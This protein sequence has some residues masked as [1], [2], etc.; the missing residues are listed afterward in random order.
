MNFFSVLIYFFSALSA[1]CFAV[2]AQAGV[3]LWT[4][5]PLIATTISV[6]ENGFVTVK[7]RVTNQSR[8]THELRL[9]ALPA[10]TQLTTGTVGVCGES[11][12][13]APQ[14]SCTLSLRV[15]GSQLTQPISRGPIVC[16]GGSALQC[17]Q[18]AVAD[19]LHLTQVAALPSRATIAV[20]FGT[21]LPSQVA[22]GSSVHA[23]YQ[24]TNNSLITAQNATIVSLPPHTSIDPSGCGTTDSFTLAPAQTCILKTIISAVGLTPGSIIDGSTSP[25]VLTACW[26]DGGIVDICAGTN[27][28]LHLTV[29]PA[30]SASRIKH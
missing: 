19:V 5:T 28:L 23:I 20:K 27:D 25:N 12:I 4:F 18:P 3:P 1:L 2:S 13:L 6:P 9:Q 14:A 8:K 29:I 11:F 15:D 22:V 10:V 26:N 30:P 17:Y 21:I 16:T 7:Y 24:I